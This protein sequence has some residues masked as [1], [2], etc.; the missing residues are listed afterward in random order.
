MEIALGYATLKEKHSYRIF[1]LHWRPQN[2]RN[3]R[4]SCLWI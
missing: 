4:Y 3:A 1:F 2:S